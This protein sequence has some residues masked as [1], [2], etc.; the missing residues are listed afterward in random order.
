MKR[1][2]AMILTIALLLGLFSGC[3]TS[4]TATAPDT[5]GEATGDTTQDTF[6]IGMNNFSRGVNTLDIMES[7][8]KLV[9][10]YMGVEC[11]VVNDEGSPEKTISN[12]QNMISSGVDAAMFFVVSDSIALTLGNMCAEAQVPF[13]FNCSAITDEEVLAAL[14]END[15]YLGT[16]SDSHVVAG[17]QMAYFALEQGFT[18]ALLTG[19]E[20]GSYTQDSKINAF[21]EIFEAG[22][23]TILGEARCDSSS[24]ASMSSVTDDL[25][26]ANLEADC[27]YAPHG[28]VISAVVENLVKY[29]GATD[30]AALCTDVDVNTVDYINSGAILGANYS[31]YADN[32]YSFI[33]LYNY[34][35]G[36][37]I[38]DDEGNAPYLEEVYTDMVTVETTELY[39]RFWLEGF[40]FDED[41]IASM[42][43]G[44]LT[45]DTYLATIRDYTLESVISDKYSQGLV[46]DEEMELAGLN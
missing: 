43:D 16:I 17:E 25:I 40:P 34:L 46:T 23:G 28:S 31:S 37:Q 38:L 1:I 41:Y 7:Y 12:A 22:G 39:N 20:Y 33:L 15:Y 8:T 36:N 2:Y 3:A 27:I 9:C 26:A 5:D 11:F 18:T 42:C 21:T 4:T 32:V 24:S 10:D 35:I 45:Y 44:T 19:A 6:V 13:C 14:S 30:M 29:E